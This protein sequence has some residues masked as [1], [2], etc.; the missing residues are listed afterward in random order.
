MDEIELELIKAKKR[1]KDIKKIKKMKRE[2]KRLQFE[3]YKPSMRILVGTWIDS[4]CLT[5]ENLVKR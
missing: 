5:F 4:V 2:V 3:R 1:V